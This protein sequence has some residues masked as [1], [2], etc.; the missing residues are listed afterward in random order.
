M[1]LGPGEMNMVAPAEEPREAMAVEAKTASAAAA[2]AIADD[3]ALL[4]RLHDR[5]ID[6]DAY[7]SLRAA[8]PAEWFALKLA[9]HGFDEATG[10]FALAFERAPSPVSTDVLDELAAEYAAIYLMHGYQAAPAESVWVDDDGLERQDPMFKVRD[11][12]ARFGYKAPDWRK[13]SD[14]H[15]AHEL[16]FLALLAPGLGERETAEPVAAFLREHPLV[17]APQFAARVATRCSSPFYAAVALITIAYLEALSE[18]LVR[19]YGFDMTPIVPKKLEAKSN[20]KTC[21]DEPPPRYVP[22]LG[23]SW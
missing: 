1:N 3:L 19:L 13:R 4:A 14:D 5:E 16:A 17:W 6:A 23:P 11:W 20:G 10:L 15:I 22:G 9:G 18:T 7:E 12:Y 2:A 21:A 8:P